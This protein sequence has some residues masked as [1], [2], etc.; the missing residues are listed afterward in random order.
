MLPCYNIIPESRQFNNASKQ[1]TLKQKN[2]LLLKQIYRRNGW[3]LQTW[4]LKYLSTAS[5]ASLSVDKK[6]EDINYFRH[7]TKILTSW[8]ASTSMNK[9]P[10]DF[11][12]K[13]ILQLQL[14]RTSISD[15]SIINNMNTN[16]AAISVVAVAVVVQ[17][18]K[19]RGQL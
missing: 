10:D 2:A 15:N 3:S 1:V 5:R 11:T 19:R 16:A 8:F 14:I 4:I 12:L 6:Q 17:Q 18:W 13:G 9:L 7:E